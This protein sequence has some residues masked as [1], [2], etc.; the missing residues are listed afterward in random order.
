MM[1]R[2]KEGNLSFFVSVIV[3]LVA[4]F[5]L[6]GCSERR[7]EGEK[8][9]VVDA[10]PQ[11]TP[12]TTT[13]GE[14]EHVAQVEEFAGGILPD[15][16]K[17]LKLVNQLFNYM[18]AVCSANQECPATFEE[19]KEGIRKQFGLFWPKDPW[20]NPY[21]YRR[22]DERTFDIRSLGP[23]GELDT[24]DDITVSEVNLVDTH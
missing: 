4:F 18:L 24:A 21:H 8:P 9:A 5:A 6:P 2:F 22:L 19:A 1:S 12:S 16:R 3:V 23:D 15:D 13:V 14:Y 10:L 20:G 11:T 17:A 7:S